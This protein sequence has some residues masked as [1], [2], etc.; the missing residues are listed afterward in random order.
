MSDTFIIKQGD[1]SPSFAYTLYEPDRVTP[2]NLT[3]A[4]VVFKMGTLDALGTPAVSAAAAIVSSS[5]GQVRYDWA[6]G[7]TDVSGEKV[8]E[9]EVTFA[10][11][12][13]ETYP[14]KTYLP[15]FITPQIG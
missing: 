4:S 14:N 9:W 3:G 10:D 13:I 5:G 11:G 2:V 7:D 12:S 6:K 15:I 8:A 1:T